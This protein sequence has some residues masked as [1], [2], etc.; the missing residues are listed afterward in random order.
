MKS[1]YRYALLTVDNSTRWCEN[2]SI[3]FKN[4]LIADIQY[5]QDTAGNDFSGIAIPGFINVHSHAFQR[6]MAGLTEFRSSENDSFWTWRNLMYQFL[7]RLSPE[8]C[9]TI[10]RQLFIEMLRS[11]F[12]TVGEFH[13][14]HC[15]PDGE[16]YD[17]ETLMADAVVEA[18][19]ETGINVC[20][21]PVLYQRGGFDG[22]PLT[23]AQ[24][25]FSLSVKDYL[26]LND[27]LHQK[28]KDHP[29][30]SFGIAIHSLRAVDMQAIKAVIQETRKFHPGVPVH[31][32]VAEQQQEVDD[33]VS[34]TGKRPV[35]FLLDEIL[36]MDSSAE[37]WCLI[38]ATHLSASECERLA[39]SPATVGLCPT[40]EANLGDGIFPT[41]S[42]LKSGGNF[43]IGTDSH[44]SVDPFSDLRLIEYG[45]R[46]SQNR[47]AVMSTSDQSTGR[48]LCS[49]C[50]SGGA[51]ALNVDA[52]AL[53]IGRR[54]DLVVLDEDHP[55]L[56]GREGDQWL[57]SILF[58][59]HQQGKVSQL[60]DSVVVGGKV[61][62]KHGTHK[63]EIESIKQYKACVKNLTVDKNG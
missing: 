33:C 53:A 47:R 31:I 7:S 35:E 3:S 43:S 62:I 49:E 5:D 32:H 54:A 34:M 11:G 48:L 13:Y 14:V 36:E 23:K 10:A 38:H 40:T 2:V 52:G 8:D 12:T 24:G 21:M 63:S 51:K 4:E 39:C 61:V 22:R 20:M 16:H 1:N 17:P 59:E 29:N 19:I 58:C 6:A 28:W 25:R 41:E 56:V 15:R 45:Q 9:R 37:R 18:A 55:N 42:F 44:I 57:D 60:V 30:V 46:L 27:R 26:Q 50:W